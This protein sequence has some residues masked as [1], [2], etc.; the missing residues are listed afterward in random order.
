MIITGFAWFDFVILFL[1]NLLI[2]LWNWSSI[3]EENV[4]EENISFRRRCIR[5]SRMI[6][7]TALSCLLDIRVLQNM[8]T[9]RN[10]EEE[11]RFNPG[12][13]F[14][15]ILSSNFFKFFYKKFLL[16]I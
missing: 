14:G 13:F 7:R 8:R 11:H 15:L 10:L 6:L 12:F 9:R 5:I 2:A 16:E 1:W 4:S 3:V